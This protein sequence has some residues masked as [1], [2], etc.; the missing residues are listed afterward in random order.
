MIVRQHAVACDLPRCDNRSVASSS[1]NGEA[2]RRLAAT[3][4]WRVSG[5]KDVCPDDWAD[6]W[7]YDARLGWTCG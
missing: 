1:V 7:R 2:A 6:G 4:G 3:E 5:S